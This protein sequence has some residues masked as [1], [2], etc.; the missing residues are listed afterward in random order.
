MSKSELKLQQS[1]M[2]ADNIPIPLGLPILYFSD[3][4]KTPYPAVHPTE[5]DKINGRNIFS[6]PICKSAKNLMKKKRLEEKGGDLRANENQQNI[7]RNIERRR[8]SLNPLETAITD[9]TVDE[10]RESEVFGTYDSMNED[11][12]ALE[13][14]STL[15]GTNSKCDK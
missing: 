12:Y 6:S 7:L 2:G 3:E 10:Q 8:V 1:S 9:N 15:L 5:P 13:I 14:N 4:N 11:M